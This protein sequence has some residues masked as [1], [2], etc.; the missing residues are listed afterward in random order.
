MDSTSRSE[1]IAQLEAE[2]ETIIA[3]SEAETERLRSE[4]NKAFA[5]ADRSLNEFMAELEK[6]EKIP[7]DF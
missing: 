4:L 2:L 6:V 1:E 5:E 3:N 7:T